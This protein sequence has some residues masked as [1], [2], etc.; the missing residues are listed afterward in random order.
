MSRNHSIRGRRPRYGTRAYQARSLRE[1][2]EQDFRPDSCNL[3]LN[4]GV[5]AAQAVDHAHLRV[6]P[7]Y[8]G[9]VPEPRSGIPY[10]QL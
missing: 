9:D 5:A 7:R 4:V 8:A 3:G 1:L 6:I 10:W 2:L